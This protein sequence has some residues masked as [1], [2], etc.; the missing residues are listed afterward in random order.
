MVFG[1]N[2]QFK[3]PQY[4][5]PV[6]VIQLP[7]N[8][9]NLKVYGYKFKYHDVTY[10]VWLIKMPVNATEQSKELRAT[11]RNL[12]INLLRIHLEKETIRILLNGINSKQIPLE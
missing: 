2:E 9:G 4:A 7:D 3:L 10:K 5:F 6:E 1:A 12:R 8:S 11:V